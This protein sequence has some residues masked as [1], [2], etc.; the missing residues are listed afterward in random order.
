MSHHPL[1]VIGF[2]VIR[3]N[4]HAWIKSITN[5]LYWSIEYFVNALSRWK[6][7]LHFSTTS[8]LHRFMLDCSYHV[9]IA[10]YRENGWNQVLHE[11]DNSH[12]LFGKKIL[13]KL[14]RHVYKLPQKRQL[15]VLHQLMHWN[16]Y[17]IILRNYDNTM[18]INIYQLEISVPIKTMQFFILTCDMVWLYQSMVQKTF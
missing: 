12:W 8:L 3:V 5:C 18:N 15:S 7:L 17:Y 2:I 9:C 14:Y 6:P 4:R 11:W 16:K 1:Q 13:K 10:E